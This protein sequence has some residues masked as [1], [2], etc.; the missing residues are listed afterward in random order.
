[1]ALII[2]D[3]VK[4]TTTTTGT[5]TF[6][7][8]GTVVSYQ[9]FVAGIGTTNETFYSITD[10][11]DWEVGIGTV[12]DAATDTLSRTTILASSNSDAAVSWGAGA[13]E[14]FCTAPADIFADLRNRT[15]ARV[16]LKDYGEVTNAI[17]SI[18]GGTQDIDLLLG[19]SIVA[20][21]DTSATTFTFSNP[22]VSDELSGFT[23]YLTN[24]GSQTVTWPA[25]VD[26]PVGVAPALTA[27]GLDILVFTTVDGGTTWHG[28]LVSEDSS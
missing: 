17:G 16:N 8:D 1:M 27:A 10:G 26:W 11:T 19:N 23:L 12:T 3:R 15:L 14:I 6:D 25:S 21:V 22:K 9:T 28:M 5:G 7:L 2:A 18:G 20:T 13:K 24:G 4:Q